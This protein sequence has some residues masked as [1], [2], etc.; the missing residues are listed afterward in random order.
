MKFHWT[1]SKARWKDS[2]TLGLAILTGLQTIAE[3]SG[4]FEEE[5]IKKVVWWEK[6]IWIVLF[7]VLITLIVFIVKLWISH[8]GVKFMVGNNE[9]KIKQTD[10]F[11]QK[12]FRL[13]PFN[14]F[15]DTQVD[16]KIIAKNTLNGIFID[17]YVNNLA[18][19]QEAINNAEEVK[20]LSSSAFKGKRR[21]PLGRIIK[22]QDYLLLA[23]TH[24][25]DNNKAY[26][27]HVDYEKCLIK[28]W[29]EIDRVY[30]NTPVFIPLLGGGIT[31]FKDTPHKTN[32]DLIQCLICTL[33][34]SGIFLKQSITICLTEEAMNDIN[35]Y[36]LKSNFK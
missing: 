7:F 25:D 31:R 26:L 3:I 14:E 5:S 1:T 13:I 32:S 24:F 35:I 19:L 15:F 21:F 20:G 36:E 27:T 11:K 8:Y 22:F 29:Q 33:K 28:M 30:A 9:V 6:L 10:L 2:I 16:G 12:G 4:F 17:K 23:F 34:M 18:E